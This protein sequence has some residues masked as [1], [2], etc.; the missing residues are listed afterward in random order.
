M[1]FFLIWLYL[2]LRAFYVPLIYDEI[3]TFYHY[4]HVG[5]FIPFY[6]HWDANNHI[7]NS[8]LSYLS[9]SL[10]G[11]SGL[12]LRLSNLIFVPLF[13]YF[14][15]KISKEL[16]D[17]ILQWVFILSICCAH[18]FIEFF[19]LSRGY[20]ISMTLIFGSVWY[21]INVIKTNR[22]K[23]YLLCL[24]SLIL[25]VISNLTLLNSAIIIIG[26]L[27]I[28]IIYNYKSDSFYKSLKLSASILLLGVLPVIMF[29]KLLFVMREKELLY[30]GTTEGFWQLSV[31]TLIKLITG[32]NA[33]VIGYFVIFFF[34]ILC[35]IFIYLFIQKPN[36]KFFLNSNFAFMYLLLGNIFAVILL[37]KLFNINYPEDRTGLYFLPFFIGSICFMTDQLKRKF[38]HKIITFI[39]LPLLFFPIHFIYNL[40]LSFSSHENHRIPERFYEKVKAYY[41]PGETPPTVGGYRGRL[42]CWSYWNF[43]DGGNLCKIYSSDFP[44]LVEDF[45]IGILNQNPIWLEYYDSID[46]D[47]YSNFHLLKR[48]HFLENLFICGKSGITTNGEIKNEY[49]NLFEIKADTLAGKYLYLGYDL[50]IFSKQKPFKAWIVIAVSN[51]EQENLRYEFIALDWLRTK[52]EGKQSNFINGMLVHELPED[53]YSIMTY[54][55]N[56]NKVPYLIKNGKCSLYEIKRD[57]D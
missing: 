17:K 16:S 46:Y 23:H 19:A 3:A 24:I 43:K 29:A 33:N 14:I 56:V 49:F 34:L 7:I 13:F 12:A 6:A 35:L 45:Q 28:N 42:M 51:K 8:L 9:Y 22:L 30:Y 36:L 11:S 40:N 37:C 57:Y 21:L 52:W 54:L 47:K 5:K 53:A 25:A 55:W 31:K 4:V 2:W 18:N 1:L 38:N 26:I 41:I 50:T 39:V 44:G 20:G 10:F 15:Y 48:K 32:M 27:I